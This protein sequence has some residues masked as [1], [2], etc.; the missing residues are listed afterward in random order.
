MN[1]SYSASSKQGGIFHCH[2]LS[3]KRNILLL[4]NSLPTNYTWIRSR[5]F[6]AGMIPEKH[7][8]VIVSKHRI[9][10]IGRVLFYT[11]DKTKTVFLEIDRYH[12]ISTKETMIMT[13]RTSADEKGCALN[14]SSCL[15][16]TQPSLFTDQRQKFKQ[17][18]GMGIVEYSCR[19]N[20]GINLTNSRLKRSFL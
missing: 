6:I 1:K 13:C 14:R 15:I 19:T 11:N 17:L 5:N 20:I 18:S 2:S 8:L 10:K 16:N 12:G 9:G 3:Y 7:S 4:A